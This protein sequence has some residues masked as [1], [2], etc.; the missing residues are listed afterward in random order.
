MILEFIFHVILCSVICTIIH[1]LFHK[2]H[3]KCVNDLTEEELIKIKTLLAT[4]PKLN[5]YPLKILADQVS[6]ERHYCKCKS[7][8]HSAI[9]EKT[10]A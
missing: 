2:K 10:R 5:V 8:K 3:D 9:C 1:V 6:E 7:P 4:D